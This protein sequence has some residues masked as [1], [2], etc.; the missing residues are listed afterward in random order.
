MF[1]TRNAKV[2]KSKPEIG[3]GVLLYNFASV[4]V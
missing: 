2:F 4:Y 3:A 1:V